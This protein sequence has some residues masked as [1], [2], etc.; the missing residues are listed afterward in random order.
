MKC[1]FR[2]KCIICFI[3]IKNKE[4]S[5]DIVLATQKIIF[6]FV[7]GMARLVAIQ[8]ATPQHSVLRHLHRLSFLGIIVAAEN[9]ALQGQDPAFL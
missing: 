6:T 5:D 3:V 4:S 8:P 2:I 1:F 7:H 9:F